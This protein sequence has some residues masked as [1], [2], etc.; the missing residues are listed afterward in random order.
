MEEDLN[1]EEEIARLVEAVD[2]MTDALSKINMILI[3]LII[4]L[5]RE[6]IEIERLPATDT[7][8]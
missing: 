1:R 8:Q 5:E 7:F 3:S 6:G 4:T 2:G